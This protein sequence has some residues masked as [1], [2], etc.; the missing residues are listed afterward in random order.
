MSAK[1]GI[2]QPL[3]AGIPAIN[4]DELPTTQALTCKLKLLL[5]QEQAEAVRRTALV[6]RN[7][8]NHACTVAFANGKMSQGMKLQTLVYQE[9]RERFGLPS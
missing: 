7:A 1:C 5:T 2:L 9:L 6:Y 8:L 4:V 3:C